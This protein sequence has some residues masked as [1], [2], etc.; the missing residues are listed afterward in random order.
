MTENL[1]AYEGNF[2]VKCHYHFKLSGP[3][4]DISN[5]AYMVKMVED[6]LVANGVI[7]EDDQKYVSEIR[8][9]AE[10]VKKTALNEVDVT[11]K[12]YV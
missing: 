3:Q 5:H 9:T 12:P 8:V 6:A 1:S 10:K 11:I 4:L 2:P 7:P